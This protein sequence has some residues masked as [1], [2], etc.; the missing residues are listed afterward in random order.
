MNRALAINLSFQFPQAL[1]LGLALVAMTASAVPVMAQT[2]GRPLGGFE[3]GR[4]VQL[5]TPQSGLLT[6]QPDRLFSESLF[7]KRVAQEIEAEGAVLTAENRT[8]EADLRAEEQELTQRRSSM[9]AEAFR[10]LADAFDRKVQETR[11]TQDQKL[12]DISMMGETA[13]REFFATSLPILEGI[14][15]ETGAGAI[16]DHATVFLSADVVDITDLAIDRIDKVLGDGSVTLEGSDD[17]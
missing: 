13:R 11:S 15:R 2:V 1:A 6:I 9:D 12:R 7:G 3:L 10:T 5:G 4:D 14:M 17:Q 8:I 16:L